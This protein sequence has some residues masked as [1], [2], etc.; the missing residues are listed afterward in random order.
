MEFAYN[1]SFQIIIGMAP[2]EALYDQKCRSSIYWEEV[3]EKKKLGPELVQ[4][5]FEKITLIR[6]RLKKF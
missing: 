6:K 3:G 1:N 2:F 4:P 5:T